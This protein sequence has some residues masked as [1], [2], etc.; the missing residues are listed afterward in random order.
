M[1]QDLLISRDGHEASEASTR[2]VTRVASEGGG[3]L[4]RE[5]E[6]SLLVTRLVASRVSKEVGSYSFVSLAKIP[7]MYNSIVLLLGSTLVRDVS[8]LSRT[9]HLFG[10]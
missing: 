10:F 1:L 2:R 7:A 3:W 8:N 5:Y 9:I 6:A 4:A